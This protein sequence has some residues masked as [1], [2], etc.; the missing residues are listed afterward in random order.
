[1]SCWCPFGSDVRK[2]GCCKQI[3]T[4]EPGH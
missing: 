3:R 2:R 4:S 1:M